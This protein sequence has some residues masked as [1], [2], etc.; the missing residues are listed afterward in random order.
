MGHLGGVLGRLGAL[1]GASWGAHGGSWGVLNVLGTS[2]RPSRGLQ[3]R[4][5]R[6]R[7]Y[8]WV[9]LEGFWVVKVCF[10]LHFKGFCQDAPRRLQEDLILEVF[11]AKDS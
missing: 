8:F 1:L 5:L 9:I 2:T 7:V 10:G 4:F 6:F 11:G 3:D